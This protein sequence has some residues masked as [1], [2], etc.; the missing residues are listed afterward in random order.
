M[1]DGEAFGGSRV[2]APF[3]PIAFIKKPIVLLRLAALVSIIK[4]YP[5]FSCKVVL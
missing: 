1:D 5:L 3:D 2:G 4:I